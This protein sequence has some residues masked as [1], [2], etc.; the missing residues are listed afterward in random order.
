MYNS[1][2]F[3]GPALIF[4]ILLIIGAIVLN[5]L[6]LLNLQN[7][8]KQV[9]EPRRQ[10]PPANVWLMFIP[11]FNIIYP[12]ILY[13][14]ICDSVKAEYV[15]RGLPM[16]GDFARSIGVTMPILT[17]VGIVPVIGPL[18]SLA[19]FVLFIIFWSKTA[20]FKNY[21]IRNQGSPGAADIGSS[22][23]LLDN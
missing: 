1:Y 10:V 12:F 15:H 5:V 7:T 20:G 2:A 4:V 6:Y 8:M 9:G 22:S 23:D 21:L 16:Q 13:P 14:K 18:A 3:Q 19:G 11:L 17:L